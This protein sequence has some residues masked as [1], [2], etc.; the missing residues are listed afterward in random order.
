MI[1]IAILAL[2]LLMAFR[3]RGRGA[4]RAAPRLKELVTVTA[5]LVRI[6]DLVDNAGPA[7]NIAVFRAPDLGQTGAVQVARVTEALKAARRRGSTPPGSARW[8]SRGCPAS[9]PARTSRS[10]SRAR[11]PANTA[12]ATPRISRSRST[13]RCA[14]CTS[15]RR[16]PP[17]S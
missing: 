11:S 8:W 16:R 14:R 7:A 15:K 4:G 3:P 5:D 9:S 17:T 1:R 13:A 2:A 10:A 6:G 12:S